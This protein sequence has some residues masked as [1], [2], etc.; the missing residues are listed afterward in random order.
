MYKRIIFWQNSINKK[1]KKIKLLVLDFDGVL[2]NNKV[3][4]DEH[5]KESVICDRSDGMG[6]EIL[7][8]RT[9]VEIIVLS[10]ERNKTVGARC[11][12]L[13]IKSIQG[14][15][16]KANALNFEI[17]KRGLSYSEVCFVGNDINDL[18]CLK[19][20]GIGI[21]VADSHTSVLKKADYITTKKGG[22]GA[23]R[24]ICELLLKAKLW[25]IH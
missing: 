1:A 5:G 25:K 21:G 4:V 24:E 2:T 16:D 9:N 3:I 7:K 18:A 20:A 17:K 23:V 13:G 12:K 6:I 15:D 11:K 10:K 14:V 22:D 19:K 8:K